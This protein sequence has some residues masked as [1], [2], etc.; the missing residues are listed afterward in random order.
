MITQEILQL[1]QS[2]NRCL[3]RLMDATRVFLNSPIE[4]LILQ[5]AEL[6]ETIKTPLDH[7][8]IERQSIIRTIELHDK[9]I[10][11]LISQ[12]K[13][14]E[15]TKD[16]LDQVRSELQKNEKLISSL[17]NADDMVFA[18][19]R[20]AQGQITKLIHENRKS[21]EILSKFKSGTLA[22]GEGMDKTL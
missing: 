13:P 15:K 6:S 17:F 22:T 9:K 20:E 14:P 10:N 7:Y 16:F 3:V 19:I 2:K 12:M 8:E 4:M 5:S 21:G 1:I 18:R 11:S